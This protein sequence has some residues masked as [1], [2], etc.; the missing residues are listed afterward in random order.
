MIIDGE[1]E[2]RQAI[3]GGVE[4]E[5]LFVAEGGDAVDQR[6]TS[7][8]SFVTQEVMEKIAYGDRRESVVAIAKQ[9][10]LNLESFS[11][12]LS[13]YP[14]PL[15]PKAVREEEEKLS[16]PASGKSEQPSELFLV[17]DS[18]EKPGNLGA[19]L[20]TAD[21]VGVTGV[22]LTDPVCEVWNPNA[23]R[24]SMGA[25]FRV[26][27]AV[28]SAREA[29]ERLTERGVTI[30]AARVQASQELPQVRFSKKTAI[31]VG[32]EAAGLGDCWQR[33]DIEGVRLPMHGSVDSLNVSVSAAVLLYHAADRIGWFSRP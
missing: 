17:I 18:V 6:S 31:V 9:P 29:I 22:L 32:S 23:I 15:S 10:S 12:R 24:S 13:P 11:Q 5:E 26:P 16:S 7:N 4:I 28:A 27:M 19:M 1:R 20:R 3:Q 8:T 25:I 2:L 30:M 33:S 14:R 21:A